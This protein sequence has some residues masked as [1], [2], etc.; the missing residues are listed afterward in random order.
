MYVGMMFKHHNIVRLFFYVSYVNVFFFHSTFK[1]KKNHSNRKWAHLLHTQQ[2][3][4]MSV[5]ITKK[6]NIPKLA[7]LYMLNK[8]PFIMLFTG[9]KLNPGCKFIL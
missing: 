8:I 6:P 1:I 7:Y 9:G 3:P 2:H 4:H 5:R